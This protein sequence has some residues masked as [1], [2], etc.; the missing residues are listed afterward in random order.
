MVIFFYQFDVLVTIFFF[1]V[2]HYL[3]PSPGTVAGHPSMNKFKMAVL[4][5]VIA[6]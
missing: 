1:V 6:K 2:V 3:F 5:R 4:G